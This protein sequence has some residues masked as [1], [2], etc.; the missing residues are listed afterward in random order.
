MDD[1]FDALGDIIGD[2]LSDDWFFLF[3]PFG[4][5]LTFLLIDVIYYF[6]TGGWLG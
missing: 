2:A 5:V 1:I 6:C 3:A 4:L